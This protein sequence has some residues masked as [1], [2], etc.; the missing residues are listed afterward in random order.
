MGWWR[1]TRLALEALTAPEADTG[2]CDR[3]MEQLARDSRLG[4]ALHRASWMIRAAWLDSRARRMLAG[5]QGDVAP[6]RVRG[7]VMVVTGATALALNA[8]K[9]TPVGPLSTLVPSLVIVAGVLV[10]L[11][12]GPLSRAI[13]HRTS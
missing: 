12:A 7:W 3:A 2:S 5:V 8:I 10:M 13:L 4:R 6:L 11:M 9:P 1:F